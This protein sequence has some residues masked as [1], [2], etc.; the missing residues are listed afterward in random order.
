M[1]ARADLVL[2]DLLGEAEDGTL[3]NATTAPTVLAPAARAASHFLL[4]VI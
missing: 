4:R 3:D 1:A 2:A